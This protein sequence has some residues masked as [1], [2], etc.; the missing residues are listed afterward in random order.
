MSIER[1]IGAPHLE[2]GPLCVSRSSSVSL[3]VPARK[4]ESGFQKIA[5]ISEHRDGLAF[6]V[7]GVIDRDVSAIFIVTIIGYVKGRC[8]TSI[9]AS[10]TAASSQGHGKNQD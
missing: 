1:H 10:T 8:S 6:F 2:F 4:G 5:G 3:R 9:R 7:I